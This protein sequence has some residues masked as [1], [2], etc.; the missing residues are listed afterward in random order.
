LKSVKIDGAKINVIPN[1]F[2]EDDFSENSMNNSEEFSITYTG[3]F[4]DIYKIDGFLAAFKKIIDFHQDIDIKLKFIGIISNSLPD[5]IE[6]LNLNSFV[7]FQKYVPHNES[8]AALQKSTILLLVIPN[9]EKNE[10]ILTGKLFEYLG[11]KKPILCIGPPK[12]DAAMIIDECDAGK[13]FDYDNQE[14]MFNFIEQNIHLWKKKAEDHFKNNKIDI[15]SRKNLTS[16][17]ANIILKISAN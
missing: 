3:T 1:G 7:T 15:Y 14:D 4:A 6:K 8:I 10:G 5:K 13:V 16:D 11:S 9:I 2:D 17:L 12:G